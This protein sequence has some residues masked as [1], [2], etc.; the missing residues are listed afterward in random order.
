MCCW[1]GESAFQKQTRPQMDKSFGGNGCVYYLVCGIKGVCICPNSSTYTHLIRVTSKCTSVKLR[2]AELPWQDE[3][4]CMDPLQCAPVWSFVL[5]CFFSFPTHFL[6]CRK[7][8]WAAWWSRNTIGAT[9]GHWWLCGSYFLLL[10]ACLSAES[11]KVPWVLGFCWSESTL[12]LAVMETG[13]K[14]LRW[15]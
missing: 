2:N 3:N 5:F 7:L 15:L 13:S 8:L 4:S 9:V 10:L 1:V 11:R 6:K 12:L 14:I